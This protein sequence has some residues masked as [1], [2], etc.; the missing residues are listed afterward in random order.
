[1]NVLSR[2]ACGLRPTAPVRRLDETPARPDRDG[3]PAAGG[4]PRGPRPAAP[5]HSGA[6]S[7]P[8]RGHE[9]HECHHGSLSGDGHAGDAGRAAGDDTHGRFVCGATRRSGGRGLPVAARRRG[10]RVPRPADAVR[11]GDAA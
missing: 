9:G 2:T 8:R 10:A 1:M 4:R 6:R 3:P 11:A 5:E 7:G